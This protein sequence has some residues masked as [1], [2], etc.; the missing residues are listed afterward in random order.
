MST[1]ISKRVFGAM[2]DG[3]PVHEYEFLDTNGAS[4]RVTNYG[5]I[6]T[7]INVPD[8]N[9]TFTNVVLG[10]ETFEPYL[11]AH[12][13]FGAITGR[14]AGRLP[15]GQF[16]IDG[17]T[18]QLAL[19]SNGINHIH[20]GTV[21]LDK[22][23]W[24]AEIIPQPEGETLRLTYTSPD[25]E[26]GYPGTMHIAVV[27]SFNN[28]VFTMQT[29]TT[30]DKPTIVAL[31]NH[32]YF[33][34]AGRGD[35][36]AHEAQVFA[37]KYFTCEDENR[38]PSPNY[39]PVEGTPADWRKPRTIGDA[40]R[41]GIFQAHGDFYFLG[42]EPKT[43]EA[44]IVH[45]PASGRTLRVESDESCLQFYFG[46]HLDGSEGYPKYSGF[47]LECQ[48]YPAAANRPDLGDIVLH[49]GET[50]RRETRYIFGAN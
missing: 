10:F 30:T 13:F 49:P 46:S 18:Y 32:S 5:G 33:N 27:Y 20:G 36:L 19:N 43:R 3:T 8:K 4:M 48:D 1:K 38:T 14:V 29:E 21:G 6:V 41:D 16:T 7:A 35:I 31:T 2:P 28:G 12:P 15:R 37:D 45:D 26:E 42:A 22:R 24:N 44:A 47:C 9:S 11:A 17:K 50:R 25:G 39:S 34:L 40:V 23:L